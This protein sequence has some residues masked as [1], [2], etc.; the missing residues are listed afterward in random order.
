MNSE[1]TQ[2]IK[3][4][5]SDMIRDM[6]TMIP[7]KIVSFDA[8]KCE[9]TVQPIAKFRK[10]NGELLD[11][12]QINN[13]P[14]YFPQASGQ[15]VIIAYPVRENDAC[16]LFFAEQALDQW[17]TGIDF[18][19]ELKFDLTNA[20]AM[21]GL[22]AK[23][24]QIVREAQEYDA[25]IITKGNQR[26]TLRD[27]RMNFG[28]NAGFDNGLTVTGNLSVS[29]DVN[30]TQD[31]SAANITANGNMKVDGTAEITGNANIG[32]N[33]TVGGNT[34][35]NGN[36]KIDGNTDIGGELN[37]TQDLNAKSDVKITGD[38]KIGGTIEVSQNVTANANVDIKGDVEIDN[39]LFVTG[40][41]I[42]RNDVWVT[43]NLVVS[44]Y[45]GTLNKI[46]WLDVKNHTHISG[47]T[48]D[49]TSEPNYIICNLECGL[50][51]G[52][53]DCTFPDCEYLETE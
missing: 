35:I 16:M 48:D 8:D 51:Y 5:V 34:T 7:G 24:N 47:D 30:V 32:N 45:D 21:V 17:R 31:I 12:A 49:D 22:F 2:G 46:E 27:D 53:P 52:S 20:V 43:E 26:I 14:V 10:P 9:A 29:G 33:I 11:Y 4:I 19:T 39:D 42:A 40:K 13:V 50:E 3:N 37:V 28:G 38:V 6:H 1:F 15:N 25:V 44:E 18:S 41:I 23:P 36:T